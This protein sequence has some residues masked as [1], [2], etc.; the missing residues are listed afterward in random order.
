MA[1]HRP[2]ASKVTF[3]YVTRDEA[4]DEY[5]L[6]LVEDGPW[7]TDQASVSAQESRIRD[8]LVSALWIVI[9]GGLAAAVPES[10]LGN[11]RIQVDSPS[12]A[13]EWL[14]HVVRV[15]SEMLEGGEIAAALR[16]SP[17]ASSIRVVTG[18][19]L[20]RFQEERRLQ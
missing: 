9:N 15:V 12:G 16:N 8:T 17:H 20:G 4:N 1:L 10:K 14:N 18:E 6:Y 7:P 19:E 11:V 13:P 5:V 2:A 3:D